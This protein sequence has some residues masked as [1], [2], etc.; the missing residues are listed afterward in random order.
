MKPKIINTIEKLDNVIK[1]KPASEKQIFD[2][3]KELSLSFAEDYKIYLKKY[4][5]IMADGIELTGISNSKNRNVVSVT[6]REWGLNNLIRHNMYVVENV[7]IDGLIIW[8]DE[9]GFIYESKPNFEAQKIANDLSEYL[10]KSANLKMK[11]LNKKRT[12]NLEDLAEFARIIEEAAAIPTKSYNDTFLYH[13]GDYEKGLIDFILKGEEIDKNEQA[14]QDV[15]YEVKRSPYPFLTSVLK[16]SNI[17][18]LK[19]EPKSMPRSF[20]V[21]AAKDIRRDGQTKV[22]IDVTNVLTKDGASYKISSELISY[23]VSAMIYWI[24]QADPIRLVNSSKLQESGTRCFSLLFCYIIDYMRVGGVDMIREKTLYLSSLYYQLCILK[25]K[26][27]DTVRY[28][29]LKN[30]GLGPKDA[31]LLDYQIPE[32]AF[33]DINTFIN[34]LNNILKI[35]TLKIDNFIEK[36]VYLYKSGTQ[37]ATELFPAFATMMTNAYTGSYINNQKTIEKITNNGRDM[38]TF[39]TALL[40]VGSESL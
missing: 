19:K 8:Q 17:V 5:A 13:K 20:K 38:V 31:E 9:D 16:S 15:I 32:D 28:R 10:K 6:K 39:V 30:S 4:G 11:I 3:E 34:A 22:F 27:T 35:G 14:F 40:Q 12:K 37:F 2:A 18:L 26:A 21:F 7:C 33:N 36:W 29:A 25:I 24:Y 1:L 23:L